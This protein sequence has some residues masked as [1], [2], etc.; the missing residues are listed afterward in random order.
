M[1]A[2]TMKEAL[3]CITLNLNSVQSGEDSMKHAKENGIGKLLAEVTAAHELAG[4]DG[5][6]QMQAH[7]EEAINARS[8]ASFLAAL[9]AAH[10]G[11]SAALKSLKKHASKEKL[12]A[13]A[14]QMQGSAKEAAPELK[15]EQPE[16]QP[17][18][19]A[20]PDSNP[21]K[22][23]EEVQEGAQ[24]PEVL[25]P[26][27]EL[28]AVVASKQSKT[29]VSLHGLAGK[30]KRELD[31]AA[32]SYIEVGRLLTLAREFHDKQAAFLAWAEDAVQLKKAQVYKLMK[33]YE[34]FG[35]DPRFIGAPMRALYMLTGASVEQL[36]EAAEVA[37]AGE[38]DS[39]SA[40]AIVG[41]NSTSEPAIIKHPGKGTPAPEKA[42]QEP[43]QAA[44]SA[45]AAPVQQDKINE[46]LAQ[47][48]KLTEQLNEANQRIAELSKPKAPKV[49]P[50]PML[51]QFKSACMYARLGLPAEAAAKEV[52][53]AY[54]EL[55]KFFNDESNSEAFQA[56]TE[57][58]ESLLAE[59]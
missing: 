1:N 4:V 14:K 51:P 7:L 43:A 49:Q 54:R 2:Q 34:T 20:A 47:I 33:V 25:E 44:E 57:A 40:A 16:T 41:K 6:Q 24:E 8:K 58:K 37:E 36:A 55:V 48:G 23:P 29:P 9:E 12:H 35:N 22:L 11:G 53:A 18:E 15:Q 3:E 45:P 32:A 50:M 52:R 19:V 27:V 30:I 46:L 21:E 5:V 10:K 38:L 13:K 17:E 56:I 26:E 28:P 59:K 42:Q 39:S 31:N